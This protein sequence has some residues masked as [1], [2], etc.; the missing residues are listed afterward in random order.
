MKTLQTLAERYRLIN[1]YLTGE[2]IS[3]WTVFIVLEGAMQWAGEEKMLMVIA[4]AGPSMLQH[5]PTRQDVLL[6]Q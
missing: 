3:C 5:Q 1:L 2:L 6:M 4:T